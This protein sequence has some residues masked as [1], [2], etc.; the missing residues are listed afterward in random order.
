MMPEPKRPLK[1]FLCHAHADKAKTRELY[2]YLHRRGVQ[3]WLD[4]EDLVGGQD[5]RVEI[6]KAIKASDAIIICLSKNSIN[7]EGFVQ[8]EITFALEKALEI[9]QGR[10][11]I[12]PARYEEC[13]VPDSLERFHWVDL[14]E[15]DGFPRL[16]KSFKTRAGQ[17]ERTTVQVPQPDE[18]SPNLTS[19][20]EEKVETEAPEKVALEKAPREAA[21]AERRQNAQASSGY[22]ISLFNWCWTLFPLLIIVLAFVYY[23]QEISG[24][25]QGLGGLIIIIP[26]AVIV[27]I[28]QWFLLRNLFLGAARWIGINAIYIIIV[29]FLTIM[30]LL[31]VSSNQ[32]NY[33][34]LLFTYLSF[35]MALSLWLIPNFLIGWLITK[36]NTAINS[37]FAKQGAWNISFWIRW[38]FTPFLGFLGIFVILILEAVVESIFPSLSIDNQ[39]QVYASFIVIIWGGLTGLSQWLILRNRLEK[40]WWLVISNIVVGAVLTAPWMSSHNTIITLGSVFWI[41]CNLILPPMLVWKLEVKKEKIYSEQ[42]KDRDKESKAISRPK[43]V[44]TQ[45]VIFIILVLIG[46]GSWVVPDLFSPAQVI[47]P[48]TPVLTMTSYVGSLDAELTD[49]K[50]VS[51]RL[52]PAGEFTMGST[53][54]QALAECRKYLTGCQGAMFADTKPP[55]KVYLDDFYIDKYEVTNILYKACVDAGVCQLHTLNGSYT[56]TSYYDNSQYDNYPVIF[57]NW[58]MAKTY[59]VWRGA[60]LPSEA[61]WEKAARGTDGRVYP[62][63]DGLDCNKANY[64]DCVGDTVEVGSYEIGKSPYGVYDMAGNAWEWVSSLYKPYPYLANDGRENLNKDGDRVIRGGGWSKGVMFAPSFFRNYFEQTIDYDADTSFRCADAP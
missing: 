4:A 35:A 31:G 15:E 38:L 26:S 43:M 40:F 5:W 29:S 48:N 42:G 41:L 57:V 14:F 6:P 17:L 8:A 58:N 32:I 37:F 1:V 11:F 13:E 61:E 45:V 39:S 62:W 28:V 50:G 25:M 51:M 24:S 53:T 46:V 21:E 64:G 23:S 7:K 33:Y 10:I 44:G 19:V 16:M 56:R 22:S 52:V 30:F 47:P 55:H 27:S 59:C 12:I 20:L 34:W 9:P 63:G 49:D 54:D 60:R 36:Q 18:S 3:P 2:R